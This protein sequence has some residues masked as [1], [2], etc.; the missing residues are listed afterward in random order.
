[1]S[2]A[3]RA[4]RRWIY[5]IPVLLVMAVIFVA[6]SQSGLRI[7]DDASVDKPFRVTGHLLAFASL[8]GTLLVAFSQGRTPRLRDAALAL[9]IT[10]IYALSDEWHQS[11]VADRTGRLDDVVT[12]LI[13]ATI[14]VGVAWVVLTFG[15]RRHEMRNESEN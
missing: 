1:V 6:S 11:F 15:T 13:G 7:S 3:P 14:G 12:D 2:D 9:G 4:S 8:A 10:F 5:W